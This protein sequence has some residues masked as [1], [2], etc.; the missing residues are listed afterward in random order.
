MP[1]Y[2][3]DQQ[4]SIQELLLHARLVN[5]NDIGILLSLDSVDL[6]NCHDCTRM[7]QLWLQEKA[8]N[9]TRR[10]LLTA[11]KKRRENSAARKYEAYLK[12]TVSYIAHTSIYTRT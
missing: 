12:T 2:I 7:Y 11:M 5:Y 9:A 8:E 1:D 3:L 6:G 4:P 10:I